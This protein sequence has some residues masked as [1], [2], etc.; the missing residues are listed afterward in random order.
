MDSTQRWDRLARQTGTAGI[1]G[2][3]LLFAPVI[4]VSGLGEPPLHA[5]EQEVVAFFDAT[6]E[7]GWF[8]ATETVLLIGTLV[9]LWSLVGLGLLLRRA[10]GQPAWRSAMVVVSAG[11]FAAYAIVDVSWDVAGRHGSDLDAGLAHYAFDTGNLGFANTWLALGSLAAASGWVTLETRTLPRWTG[12]LALFAA[13]GFI[14]A[15]FVWT[16][17]AWLVPYSAFWVWFLAV[18]IHLLRK[19]GS[20]SAATP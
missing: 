3:V 18:C 4:A 5:D 6:A 8:E 15:R 2:T 12:W 13:V 16:T 11:L 9:L 7:T 19:P 17:E 14:V 20:L 1:A 10:E